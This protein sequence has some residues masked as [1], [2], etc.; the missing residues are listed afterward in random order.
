MTTLTSQSLSDNNHCLLIIFNEVSIKNCIT[1]N[2]NNNNN[3]GKLPYIH[4]WLGPF[5]LCL[6]VIQN[7]TLYPITSI[8]DLLSTSLFAVRKTYY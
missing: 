8:K 3:K 4:M 1:N 7:L 6:P 2:N 5:L